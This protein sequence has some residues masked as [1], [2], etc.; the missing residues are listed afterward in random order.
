MNIAAR[1]KE[2]NCFLPVKVQLETTSVM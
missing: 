1:K 2:L